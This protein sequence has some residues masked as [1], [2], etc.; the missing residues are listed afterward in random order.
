MNKLLVVLLALLPNLVLAQDIDGADTAWILTSTALVL[1]M[2]LPGLSLFYGGLVRNKNVLSIL[3]QC[4]AIA[5]VVSVLWFSVGYSLAFG[6]GNNFI[7]DFSKAFMVGIGKATAVGSIP[8]SLFAMFQMTFAIIT[9]ALI[10]GGFAER[11]K[12]SAALLFSAFWLL[13]VYV[14]I[15]HWVWGGGWLADMGVLDFAGGLVVHITAGVSALVAAMVIGNRSDFSQKPLV[16]HNLTIAVTG[17]A[18]LWVGWFG[19]NGGSAL[20]SGGDA[21][22]A[23]LVTHLAAAMGVITWSAFEWLKYGKPTILGMIT[24]MV[25]GLGTITP[26][27]GFVSPLGAIIIG[28]LAGGIC[29]YAT[30]YLKQILKIDDSLD[31]FPVHGVGGTLGTLLVG[32]FASNNIGAFSG[33]GFAEGISSIGGQ[34]KVQ[35]IAVVAVIAW[36]AILTWVVLKIVDVIV[37]LRSSEEEE[38]TGLDISYHEEVGYD[39]H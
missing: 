11:I 16:P 14:P 3:A 30:T 31:V 12:F 4:F 22:M 29:H 36:T 1:M 37:G 38:E 15:A 5:A 35:F 26:A 19:F 13:L 9:A 2:T 18:L 28:F 32:V 23:V 27:S 21:A 7:G 39:I 24:G 10:V 33:Y 8:E 34:L 25:A 17:A 20:A 6:E